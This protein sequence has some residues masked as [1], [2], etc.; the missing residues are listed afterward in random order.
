MTPFFLMVG[1]GI[2]PELTVGELSDRREAV[3][4]VG[5]SIGAM[6][7]PGLWCLAV[8]PALARGWAVPTATEILLAVGAPSA[9]S[10]RV[11]GSMHAFLSTLTASIQ[12]AI[13]RPAGL[14]RRGRIGGRHRNLD[15]ETKPG[16]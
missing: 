12:A 16:R 9:R 14:H 7:V 2:K 1:L 5:A 11:P 10:D 8:A 3:V 13:I 6:A 4:P 15:P